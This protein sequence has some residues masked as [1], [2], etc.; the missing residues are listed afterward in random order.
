MR[1]VAGADRLSCQQFKSGG[2][3]VLRWRPNK[4]TEWV[5]GEALATA[6]RTL[7][8]RARIVGHVLVERTTTAM[9]RPTRFC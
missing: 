7:C 9:F 4:A 1:P 5:P 6:R 8:G 2:G 3:R